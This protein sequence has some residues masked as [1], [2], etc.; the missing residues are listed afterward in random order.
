MTE[1]TDALVGTVGG[2]MAIGIMANVAGKMMNGE[3]HRHRHQER[4]QKALSKS[5]GHKSIW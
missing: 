5:K 4:R 1:S 2:L 3:H